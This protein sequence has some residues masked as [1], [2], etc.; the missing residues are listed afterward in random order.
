MPELRWTLL[1]LGALFIGALAWWELRRQRQAPRNGINQGGVTSGTAPA[2][3]TSAG[4]GVGSERVGLAGESGAEGRVHREPTITFPELQPEPRSSEM[5]A[6]VRGREP[7]PDPR[8]V[9][10][11]GDSFAGLRVEGETGVTENPAILAEPPEDWVADEDVVTAQFNV[12]V[13]NE[14][15]HVMGYGR[16]DVELEFSATEAAPMAEWVAE[17]GAVESGPGGG[18]RTAAA[19]G[20]SVGTRTASGGA[21]GVGTRMASAG[22]TGTDARMATAEA[23][24]ADAH[25]TA[26]VTAAGGVTTEA[27]APTGATAAGDPVVSWPSEET[28]KIIALRLV[29]APAARFSGR[30]VRMAL[31]AEGFVLGKF[32]IFHKAGPDSRA[33]LSAASLTKPGTFALNTIDGQRFGGLSLFAVLPGPLPAQRTFD[34]LLTTARNLNDRLEGALQDERGEPLTPVRSMSIRDSLVEQPE[35]GSASDFSEEGTETGGGDASQGS[36]DARDGKPTESLQ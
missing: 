28:R 10:L 25:A 32:D 6:P 34:E 4:V 33:V 31:A 8:I 15:S 17:P 21:P 29:S 11:D 36:G 20:T 5:R 13:E 16:R 9:E 27:A 35:M 14:P 30:T 18:A 2:G 3:Y 26:N 12:G 1:V 23:T 22:A 7:T 24:G 19:G